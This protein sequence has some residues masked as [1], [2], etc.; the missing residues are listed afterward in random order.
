M[1][2]TQIADEDTVIHELGHHIVGPQEFHSAKAAALK[3]FSKFQ[4]KFIGEFEDP[5]DYDDHDVAKLDKKLQKNPEFKK[6]GM[7]AYALTSFTEWLAEGFRNTVQSPDKF[8]KAAPETYALVK[9][10]IK[11]GGT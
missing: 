2:L 6:S 5:E 10:S 11:D 3:E 7:Y 4:D 9:K 8:K 1:L